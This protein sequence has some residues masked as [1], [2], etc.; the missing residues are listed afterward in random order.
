MWQVISDPA[1]MTERVQWL[2][3]W[4]SGSGQI[5]QKVGAMTQIDDAGTLAVYLLC[6]ELYPEACS[7]SHAGGDERFPEKSEGHLI[8]L[9]PSEHHAGLVL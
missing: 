2:L 9:L 8:G 1:S 3:R 6:G 7:S 5:P 4:E